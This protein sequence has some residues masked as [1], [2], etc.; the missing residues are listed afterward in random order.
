MG[1]MLTLD[2][3]IARL[4]R[5]GQH[6]RTP[7]EQACLDAFAAFLRYDAPSA[8]RS[9]SRLATT[10]LASRL[11]PAARAL[12][13]AADAVL[14]EQP[15]AVVPL[16]APVSYEDRAA[17]DRAAYD[18]AAYGPAGYDRAGPDRSVYDRTGRDSGPPGAGTVAMNFTVSPSCLLGM[19]AGGGCR[20]PLCEH[21]CHSRPA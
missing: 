13:D 7:E 8:G 19:C 5:R 3:P 15:L 4:R 9:L 18:R 10:V 6:T 11:L 21:A 14:A 2:K 12:A 17:Y 20:S 16:G 1:V